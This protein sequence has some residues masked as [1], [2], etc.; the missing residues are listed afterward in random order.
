MAE[1]DAEQVLGRN[2]SPS[3]RVAW[4]ERGGKCLDLA[5]LLKMDGPWGRSDGD[6]NEEG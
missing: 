4:R 5:H 1:C 3:Q 2:D 6:C